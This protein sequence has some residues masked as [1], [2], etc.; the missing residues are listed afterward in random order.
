LLE[1][2]SERT[3]TPAEKT[4]LK[5]LVAE[6]EQLMIANVKRLADFAKRKSST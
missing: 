2:N 4:R 1:K 6:A 5:L 3:I